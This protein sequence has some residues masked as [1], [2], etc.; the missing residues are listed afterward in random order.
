M[1]SKERLMGLV[2]MKTEKEQLEKLRCI[3]KYKLTEKMK[4]LVYRKVNRFHT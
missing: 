4:N 2:M 3:P 1:Q